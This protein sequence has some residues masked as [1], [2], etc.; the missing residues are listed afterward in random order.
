MDQFLSHA[1]T[2]AGSL[3]ITLA[4][5]LIAEAKTPPLVDASWLAE[6]VCTEGVAVLDVR[7][8]R[9]NHEL[10]HIP[11][12]TFTDF[13]KDGWRETRNDI[14]FLLPT[15]E[16][17]AILIGSLGVGNDD[18]V[19]IVTPGTGRYDAAEA[20]AVY[21]SFR[22]LGHERVSILDG[23]FASWTNDWK[24][25]VDTGFVPPAPSTFKTK[26]VSGIVATKTDVAQALAGGRSLVDLRPSDQYLGIN[27]N[28]A[29]VRSG[30]IPGAVNV[31]LAWLMVNGTLYF[32]DPATARQAFSHAGVRDNPIL[33]CNAGLESALGWF[34]ARELLG[35]RDALLY[36]ASLAEWSRDPTLPLTVIVQEPD[37]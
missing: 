14:P 13:Y 34:V 26:P 16:H 28:K 25:D 19:V 22:V 10:S 12:S 32:H 31:P 5:P 3:A 37:S 35:E 1:R 33:F 29:L 15:P 4:A 27:R 21:V 23:G 24:N 18:H 20:A 8:S 30:T 7:R 17:L 2:V 6:R 9:A 36:D 11:C